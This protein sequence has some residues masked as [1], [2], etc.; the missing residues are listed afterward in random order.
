[1]LPS[2]ATFPLIGFVKA[3][4][5]CDS[6]IDNGKNDYKVCKTKFSKNDMCLPLNQ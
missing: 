5:A 3:G 1:M 2:I 6:V 4:H